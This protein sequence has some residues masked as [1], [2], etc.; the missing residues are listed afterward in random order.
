MGVEILFE[1]EA[2]EKRGKGIETRGEEVE[3]GGDGEERREGEGTSV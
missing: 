3:T 1:G 2:S